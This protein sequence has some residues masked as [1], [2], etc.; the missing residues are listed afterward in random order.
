MLKSQTNKYNAYQAVKGILQEYRE[1]YSENRLFTKLADEYLSKLEQ[2]MEVA[3]KADHK[4][5]VIT[6]NKYR[7]K[8][9][10]ARKAVA[11]AS[12]GMVYARDIDKPK[13]LSELKTTYSGIKYGKDSEAYLHASR[14]DQILRKH[15]D[16]L[17]EYMV[18]LADLD[19]LRQVVNDYEQILRDR[20][21]VKNVAV[22]SKRRLAGLFDQMD[23]FLYT[24]LDMVMR[25]IGESD[26]HFAA[27]Y[28]QARKIY[29]R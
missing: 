12:A 22:V 23:E 6:Q 8:E 4:T 10:M 26:A 17:G 28:F 27:H 1:A 13:L 20:D 3:I 24:K 18:T 16:S 7:M 2:I 21:G 25:R 29:D 14:I 19:D 5:N 15:I 11:L 9:L